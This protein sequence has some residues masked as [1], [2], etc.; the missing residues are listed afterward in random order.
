MSAKIATPTQSFTPDALGLRAGMAPNTIRHIFRDEPGVIRII[1]PE[2]LNKRKY[3]TMRI[4]R[5]VVVRVL[6]E[7]VL[8]A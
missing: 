4:P 8:A 7:D 6:G 1:R 3:E 5:A 2:R